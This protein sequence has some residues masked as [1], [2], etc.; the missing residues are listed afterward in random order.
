MGFKYSISYWKVSEQKP[1]ANSTAALG[2][3]NEG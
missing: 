3:K 2:L 1:I